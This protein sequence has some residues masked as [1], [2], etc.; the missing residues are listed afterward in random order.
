LTNYDQLFQRQAAAVVGVVGPGA[1]VGSIGNVYLELDDHQD[2]QAVEQAATFSH[3]K[4]SVGT[5]GRWRWLAAKACHTT[6]G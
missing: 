2:L 4:F 3:G 6:L 1:G 5:F